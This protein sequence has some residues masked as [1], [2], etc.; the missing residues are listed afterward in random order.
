MADR[1][2]PRSATHVVMGTIG[3]PWGIKGWVKLF[4]WTDPPENLLDYRRFWLDGPGGLEAI[5]IDQAKPH[6]GALVGH[7]KGCDVREACS[8]YTGR[9]LLVPKE[10]LPQLEDEYYWHQLEGLEV[11]TL[12]GAV[13]GKVDHLFETG[14]NDVMVVREPAGT[15]EGAGTTERLLPWITGQVVREVNLS[16][17]YILVDWEKDWE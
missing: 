13:L 3:A 7:I 15:E 4:S 6:G 1:V 17:G 8:R 2:H 14:A 16:A 10:A 12:S 11:R 5:E 9:E